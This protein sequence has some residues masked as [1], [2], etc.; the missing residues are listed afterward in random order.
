MLFVNQM[1]PI[2]FRSEDFK[3]DF[4]QRRRLPLLILGYQAGEFYTIIPKHA[5]PP[6]VAAHSDPPRYSH[7]CCWLV[8]CT[9][10]HLLQFICVIRSDATSSNRS[11][12]PLLT[13]SDSSAADMHTDDAKASTDGRKRQA[14]GIACRPSPIVACSVFDRQLRMF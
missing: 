1:S 10:A 9:R 13:E 3:P 6:L 8:V 12:L 4:E 2:E 5:V 11:P 7:V 14:D